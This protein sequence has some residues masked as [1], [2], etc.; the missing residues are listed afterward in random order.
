MGVG[1]PMVVYDLIKAK[2]PLG[3]EMTHEMQFQ[4]MSFLTHEIL[5]IIGS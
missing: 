3:W 2:N 4:Q 5:N 1:V